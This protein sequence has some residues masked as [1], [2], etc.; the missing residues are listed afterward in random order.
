MKP[1]SFFLRARVAP[2]RSFPGLCDIYKTKEC[3]SREIGNP[4]PAR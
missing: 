1:S 2:K 3:H 4:A